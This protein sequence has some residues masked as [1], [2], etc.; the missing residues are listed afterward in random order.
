MRSVKTVTAEGTAA[1]S[2][3][4]LISFCVVPAGPDPV[5]VFTE[6][7]SENEKEGRRG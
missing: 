6:T 3:W 4:F 7:S 1:T 2:M 5:A